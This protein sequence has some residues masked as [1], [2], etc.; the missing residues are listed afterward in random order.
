MPAV[1]FFGR[2]DLEQIFLFLDGHE[3]VFSGDLSVESDIVHTA[4]ALWSCHNYSFKR[5]PII[6][7]L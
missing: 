3:N 5:Y 7:V 2:L 6:P 1:K 4:S